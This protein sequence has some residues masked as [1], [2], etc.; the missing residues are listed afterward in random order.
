MNIL[1]IAMTS[2]ALLV[3][4]LAFADGDDAADEPT[5]EDVAT[6]APAEAPD[7]RA[8]DKGVSMTPDELI[9]SMNAPDC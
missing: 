1:R 5:G 8:C 4:P 2:A 7:E 3:S 6:E 9:A